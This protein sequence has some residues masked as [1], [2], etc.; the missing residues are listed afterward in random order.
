MTCPECRGEMSKK[1]NPQSAVRVAP[2]TAVVWECSVCGCQ[3][4]QA[5]LKQASKSRQKPAAAEPTPGI[6]ETSPREATSASDSL[7]PIIFK[8]W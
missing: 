8:T 4:T 7:R 5:E 6:A 2:G 3:L 1:W